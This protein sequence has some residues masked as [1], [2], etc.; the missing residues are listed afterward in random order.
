[1]ALW[2]LYMR[3]KGEHVNQA[4]DERWDDAGLP[5]SY[6]LEFR[7]SVARELLAKET[8][9][10][11]MELQAKCDLMH[12]EDLAEDGRLGIPPGPT[13]PEVLDR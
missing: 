6:R 1:M 10:Y 13:D 5:E 4:F 2:Q 8:K 11:R 9:Q 7:S 3:V 12:E